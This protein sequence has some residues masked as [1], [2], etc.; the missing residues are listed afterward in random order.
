MKAQHRQ[1]A[2]GWQGWQEQGQGPAIVL[3]HGISSCAASWSTLAGELPGYRVLAWDAPGYGVS[4][5][6]AGQTPNAADY[7][8]R[9]EAWL[10]D[11]GVERCV[12]VGHSL[13]ALMAAAYRARFPERLRGVV[14]ADPAAGYK[15]ESHEARERVFHSRWPLLVKLGADAFADERAPRL[16]KTNPSEIALKQ[17]KSGMRQL[18]LDGF[19]QANWMLANDDLV[20]WWQAGEPLPAQVWCG[21]EDTITTPEAVSALAERLGLPY[22]EIPQAGHASYLDAPAFF[23][24]ALQDFMQSLPTS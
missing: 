14:L 24:R 10:A 9:L 6:V 7:A 19:R 15:H 2:C 1:L 22:R 17:V 8:E 5:P 23:A 18:H 12:L 16:L 13:G 3:L 11:L 4:S 21:S 20:D